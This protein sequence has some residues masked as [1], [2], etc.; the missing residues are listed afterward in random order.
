MKSVLAET[1]LLKVFDNTNFISLSFNPDNPYS[2]KYQIEF[3][4]GKEVILSDKDIEDFQNLRKEMIKEGLELGFSL[5][6]LLHRNLEI[7][8][9]KKWLNNIHDREN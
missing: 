2:N 3:K 1:G 5:G 9:A 7:T 6:A 8:L 4:C